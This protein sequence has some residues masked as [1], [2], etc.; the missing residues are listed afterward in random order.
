M[1]KYAASFLLLVTVMLIPTHAH[2]QS[3]PQTRVRTAPKAEEVEHLRKVLGDA[4][5]RAD[6]PRQV[7]EAIKRAGDLRAPEL[8]GSLASLLTFAQ[9]FPE[10]QV[11]EETGIL[12]HTYIMS[13]VRRYPAVSALFQ[14]GK[15]ALPALV[16]YIAGSAHDEPL[17]RVVLQKIIWLQ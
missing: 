17:A 8:A 9:I 12:F 4:R 2:G 15:P 5:L 3:A 6:E 14:I 1:Q 7:I 10:D 11:A 13:V 16:K